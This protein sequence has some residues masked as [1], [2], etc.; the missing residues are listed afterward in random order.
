MINTGVINTSVPPCVLL[1]TPHH[2]CVQA[3]PRAYRYEE[4]CAA[5]R[6]PAL[7]QLVAGKG[8][9]TFLLFQVSDQARVTQRTPV[10]MSVQQQ[11]VPLQPLPFLAGL[12]GTDGSQQHV[13]CVRHAPCMLTLPRATLPVVTMPAA[14]SQAPGGSCRM[15]TVRAHDPPSPFT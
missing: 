13:G 11:R 10:C 9:P 8:C 5:E 7:G 15:L 2:N 14:A 4:D 6:M 1:R 12:P 3:V